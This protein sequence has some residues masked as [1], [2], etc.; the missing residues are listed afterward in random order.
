MSID[1]KDFILTY[2]SFITPSIK[3][4]E[5]IEKSI[6]LNGG[7]LV[8]SVCDRFSKNLGF[9]NSRNQHLYINISDNMIYVYNENDNGHE[10]FSFKK[11]IDGI[12][13]LYNSVIKDGSNGILSYKCIE[14]CGMYDIRGGLLYH[15]STIS[16]YTYINGEVATRL[17]GSNYDRVIEDQVIDGKLIR[18]VSCNHYYLSDLNFR[19]FYVSDYKNDMLLNEN[20]DISPSFSLY[21]GD[22]SSLEK[23]FDFVKKSNVKI[24]KI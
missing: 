11:G 23:K 8:V 19:E 5:Y 22:V 14:E 17:M 20:S 15:G 21:D 6:D 2:I 7:S 13:I 3:L 10:D 1:V 9:K 12:D 4:K 24:K 18:R 16:K